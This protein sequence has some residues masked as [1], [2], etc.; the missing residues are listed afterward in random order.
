M[1]KAIISTEHNQ[2]LAE[3]DVYIFKKKKNR[4]SNFSF[5]G[6]SSRSES[7]DSKSWQ[8]F[9]IPVLNSNVSQIIY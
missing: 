5:P 1:S 8:S 4:F 2:Q 9:L 7:F 3:G 6:L